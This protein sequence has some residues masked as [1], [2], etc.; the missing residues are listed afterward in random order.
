[1]SWRFPLLIPSAVV[2]LCPPR[3]QDFLTGFLAGER[4]W[5]WACLHDRQ[6]LDERD[7]MSDE[8]DAKEVAGIEIL[9]GPQHGQLTLICDRDSFHRLRDLLLPAAGCA[10]AP[11]GIEA[12]TIIERPLTAPKS[13]RFR[14]ASVFWGV[15]WSGFFFCS[16]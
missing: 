4:T 13:T 14:D 7:R 8:P 15:P 12:I 16:Y 2:R 3:D 10:S 11:D 6:A 1:V 5:D 9:K